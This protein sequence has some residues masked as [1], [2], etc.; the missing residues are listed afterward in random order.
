MKKLNRFIAALLLALLAAFAGSSAITAQDE[1]SVVVDGN[2]L[3][4]DVQPIIMNDRVMVPVAGICAAIGAAVEW[5][6]DTKDVLLTYNGKYI[7]LSAG[8]RKMLYGSVEDLQNSRGSFITLDVPPVIV[9]DRTLVPLR[10]LVEGF[11]AGVVFDDASRTVYIGMSGVVSIPE[12]ETEIPVNTEPDPGESAEPGENSEL[13]ALVIE[14]VRL[15]NVERV[16]A[17]LPVLY[18]T[19]YALY[20]AA[21]I[22]AA[23]IK[24][25][26]SKSRPDGAD[27]TT[28]FEEAGV[29]YRLAA[30]CIARN[31]SDPV[32]LIIALMNFEETRDNILNPDHVN[33]GV[34]VAVNDDGS[35][36]W[37]LTFCD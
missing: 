5:N 22:R 23:E 25:V 12:P 27:F 8:Y 10:A 29:E 20:Y 33:I 19:Y 15:C 35:Y 2:E 31:I 9:E 18:D 16:N 13:N 14:M 24:E 30:E 28:A 34:A 6:E 21:E 7:I 4:F 3:F 1:I 37:V 11:G 32:E 26:F 36:Y 17:G